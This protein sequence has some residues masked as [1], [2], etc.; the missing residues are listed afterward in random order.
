MSVLDWILVVIAVFFLVRSLLRGATRELFSLLALIL[1]GV[2]AVR[3]YS[4]LLPLLAPYI[5]SRQMQA[6][7][8]LPAVFIAVYLVVTLA[9]WL[10]SAFIRTISLSA[11]DR[12]AGVVVGA[13]K[14][15]V[16]I[17]CLVILMLKVAPESALLKRSAIL[18]YCMP[19]IQ[20]LMETL[21][22]GLDATIRKTRT[23]LQ[24][25]GKNDAAPARNE[26]R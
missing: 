10:L 26:Q 9:G 4:L 5:A 6:T 11:L 12:C 19:G 13:A 1:A 2:C 23:I 24:E 3:Y 15:Y 25:T 20:R 16:I 7:V 8:A 18:P 21:S 17:C 14:A 22:P